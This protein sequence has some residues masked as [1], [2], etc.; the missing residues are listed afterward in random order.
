MSGCSSGK[1][2]HDSLELALEALIENHIR[3]NHPA[4]AGPVN[5][6]ECD[7]CGCYHFTSQ[8]ETH[9]ILTEKSGFIKKQQLARNWENKLGW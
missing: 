1:N 5:V 7:R 3:F 8:G 2:C 4:G 6:Y 9:P